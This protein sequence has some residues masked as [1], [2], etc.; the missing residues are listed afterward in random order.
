MDDDKVAIVHYA[1][2]D[3]FVGLTPSGHALTLDGGDGP[4]PAP[5]P[6]EL[7]MIALGTCTAVDVINILKKKR[8]QITEYRVEVR[9]ERR[10]DHPRSFKRMQVHHVIKGRNISHTS[11][12]QAIELSETKYCSVA[13]TLRPTAEISS[14]FETIEED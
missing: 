1:G 13:A 12:A 2:R 4:K 3:L 11:V 6:V 8:E 5:S 10:A 7:L 14:T 9:G